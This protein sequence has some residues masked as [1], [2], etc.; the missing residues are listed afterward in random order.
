VGVEY[1]SMAEYPHSIGL[2]YSAM[3][4]FLGFKPNEG[5][6]KVMGLSS[7]GDPNIY[8]DK[9]RKLITY[10]NTKLECD[11]TM[12]SWN[13]SHTDMF[14]YELSNFLDME[15]RTPNSGIEPYHK[16]L[17]AAVQKRYE[18]LLFEILNTIHRLGNSNNLCLGG[19]S[20][21]NGLLNGKITSNTPFNNLWIPVAPSDAGSS[22][23]ACIHYLVSNNNLKRRVNR[24]PFLGPNY[25][26]NNLDRLLKGKKH[27]KF[28]SED[29]LYRFVAKSI[30][31]GK[32]VGWFQGHCE[33][34]ARALGNR[35]ILGDPR[36]PEIKTKMNAVIKKREGF[37][38]F[39]PMV[40]KEKQTIYFEMDR[41]IPY[42]NEIVKVKE[43]YRDILPSITHVDGT[44]R[45]QTVQ[46]YT[47][48]HY[49]LLEFE[50]LSGVP[51]LLNTSLNV[52]D[53]T[54]CLTPL[55]ALQMFSETEMDM[56]VINNYI[57]FK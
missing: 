56:L 20:A 27:F 35:S 43:E 7:Y 24:S 42:M 52:K 54:M 1:M 53:K 2:F 13:R 10:K 15:P 30:N 49:L 36:N 37:R 48:I 39:A 55:D 25:V 29:T 41:D 3:T 44:A 16:D 5:E 8:I 47:Q 11:L 26:M 50:K 45:V 9:V 57:I 23:G 51:I 28:K 19:G 34:G 4:A 6:Y 21:Y 38:P 32:I 40:I 12:F 22:I 14:T 33:F 31:S 46:K 18:E 17:A